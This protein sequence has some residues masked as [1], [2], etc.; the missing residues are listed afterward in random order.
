MQHRPGKLAM[1]RDEPNVTVKILTTEVIVHSQIRSLQTILQREV[2]VRL[3]LNRK[4]SGSHIEFN[5]SENEAEV[6]KDQ[7]GFTI[8]RKNES[9]WIPVI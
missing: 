9:G 1:S 3:T 7:L 2:P 4:R 8:L 5:I 6:L